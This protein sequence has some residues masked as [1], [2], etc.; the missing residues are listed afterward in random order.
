MKKFTIEEIKKLSYTDFISLI[1]EENRPSGGKKTIRDIVQNSFINE[2]SKVL[3]I[4]CTN[5]FSSL[6]IE[7]LIGCDVI[8]VDINKNSVLNA[9]QRIHKNF[10]D[11][12]KIRFEYGN[13]E[14]LQ[15]KNEVFDLI[16]C[17]NALSFINNK[18][19]AIDE[20]IRVLKP[21]GFISIV[22]IWYREEPDQNIINR[23]N[24]ELGFK[25]QCT[26]ENDWIDFIRYG[27]ELYLKK[28]YTFISSTQKQIKE[29]VDEMIDSKEHLKDYDDETI[30]F[31]K[32]RW[33][34]IINTFNDNLSMANYSVIL[35]RKM[36]EL[37][38]KEIFLTKEC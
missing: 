36:I 6:E 25:I 28:D 8:G 3:E 16:I 5:G 15:F 38:E 29:Y 23:V 10:L 17:G 20:L 33:F 12:N 2:K 30:E 34:K 32:N 4:G 11:T 22:P 9:N 13:A 37:E 18:N 1:K 35:L 24:D 7:K 27:L 14:S 19:K 31:I 21:N 26:K